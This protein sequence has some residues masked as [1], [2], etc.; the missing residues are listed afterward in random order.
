MACDTA[1]PWHRA[2]KPREYSRDKSPISDPDTCTYAALL[3]G[4][5]G[6]SRR[7][8]RTANGGYHAAD[9]ENA[10][11]ACKWCVELTDPESELD[12]ECLVFKDKCFL[13]ICAWRDICVCV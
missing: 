12:F 11:T 9:Q 7:C 4:V 8:S 5:V 13:K 2:H 3:A 6:L 1:A 10:V